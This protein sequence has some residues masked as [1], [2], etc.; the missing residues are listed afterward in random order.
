MA[1]YCN[2]LKESCLENERSFRSGQ[3]SKRP[4]FQTFF[5]NPYLHKTTIKYYK[6]MRNAKKTLMFNSLFK[7]RFCVQLKIIT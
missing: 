1:I 7:L 2:M 6:S 5:V 4:H 3:Q